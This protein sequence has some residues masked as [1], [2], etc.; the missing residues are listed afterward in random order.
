MQQR[1]L[2]LPSRC[3]AHHLHAQP[4]L[5]AQRAALSCQPATYLLALLP[6][7]PPACLP[8]N[9]PAHGPACAPADL[10]CRR[11]DG[12]VPFNT[13]VRESAPALL[14]WQQWQWQRWQWQLLL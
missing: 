4:A 14:E 11:K 6:I 8:P 10:E 2:L 13:A 5:H 3:F 1:L 9:R 12:N 7:R